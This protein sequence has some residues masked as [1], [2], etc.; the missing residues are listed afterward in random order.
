MT[1]ARVR[2]LDVCR[3]RRNG[4]T[5]HQRKRYPPRRKAGLTVFRFGRK[6][7]RQNGRT[8]TEAR[9]RSSSEVSAYQAETERWSRIRTRDTM[10]NSHLLYQAELS[11]VVFVQRNTKPETGPRQSGSQRARTKAKAKD[12]AN[13]ANALWLQVE[14]TEFFKA[15]RVL[16]FRR[17]SG[18]APTL[19]K[20]PGSNR[21]SNLSPRARRL[22]ATKRKRA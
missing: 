15:K 14:P 5:R 10:I 12:R 19:S 20:I 3:A 9:V 2:S 7:L 22:P 6:A 17:H 1:G 8:A 11:F 4:A 13:R 18:C 21:A 16:W